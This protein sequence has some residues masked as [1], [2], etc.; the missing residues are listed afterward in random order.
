MS[1]AHTVTLFTRVDCH[2]C[3]EADALLARLA[4]SMRSVQGGPFTVDAID[5]DSDPALTERYGNRVPVIAVDG[6]EIA[7]A[8]IEENSL[9]RAL[10]NA[11]SSDALSS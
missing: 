7:A 1:G 3:A 2:L 8:P 10:A 5:V 6:R 4:T 11:L 9:R